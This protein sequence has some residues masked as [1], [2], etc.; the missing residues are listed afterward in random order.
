MAI[1]NIQLT[2]KQAYHFYF[3][4]TKDLRISELSILMKMKPKPGEIF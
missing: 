1:S 2:K 3:W 4:D